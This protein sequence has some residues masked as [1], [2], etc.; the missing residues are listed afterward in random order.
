M[1]GGILDKKIGKLKL[2]L[3]KAF[4]ANLDFYF[5]IAQLSGFTIG[6]YCV[7]DIMEVWRLSVVFRGGPGMRGFIG[8][9]FL[10]WQGILEGG[11]A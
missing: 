5:V 11:A 8:G 4:P 6:C 7:I 1:I 9:N 2:L 3:L 10:T